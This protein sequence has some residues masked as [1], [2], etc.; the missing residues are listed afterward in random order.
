VS[1]TADRRGLLA[2]VLV[3]ILVRLLPIVWA[4]GVVGDGGLFHAMVEDIR[5]A[6]MTLPTT[7]TYNGLDIPFTYPPAGLLMAA[8]FGELSGAATLDLLRWLPLLLSVLCLVAV[9]WLAHRALP[10]TAAIGATLAYALMPS[11][12]GWLVAGGGLTRG[13]G[14]LF[15]I[16][17]AGLVSSHGAEPPRLRVAI[18]A[19]LL[20]GLSGLSH[21]QAAVFGVVA[22]VI[23]SYGG[24]TR[25]WLLR[26]GVAAVAAAAVVAPWIGWVAAT[27]GLDSLLA[28]GGR[29]EPA[30][31]IVR[32]LNLR[33]SAAPFMDVVGVAGAIGVVACLLQRRFRLPL[34]LLAT[35]LAGAGGGEFLAAVPWALIAGVGLAAIVDLASGWLAGDSGWRTRGTAVAVAGLAL[36]LGLIGSLG[37]VVDRSSKLHPL[38]QDQVTAMRWLATNTSADA[39]VVVPTA[40]VW[41]YD[42]VSEWLPAF[43]ERHSLGTVQ[44]SEWLGTAGYERQLAQHRRILGCVGHTAA[45]YAELDPSALIFVPKGQTAG[46]FG[47]DDCCPALRATLEAAGYEIVY[48]G[49]GATIGRPTGD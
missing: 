12:Y 8:G 31:G 7:T 4:G 36:F 10:P 45:C 24:P 21:P 19:G 49:A 2:A 42:E 22:C 18:G 3:G 40:E 25:D 11:A 23:L 1:S 6:G 28:A 38:P 37:S 29:L 9:A 44:G 41:G 46:P 20:I 30:I 26:L 15:A 16:L 32:L 47:P 35:Y 33:F 39:I 27:N 34:L 43:A 5:A 48:D 13:L 17:A 14:L